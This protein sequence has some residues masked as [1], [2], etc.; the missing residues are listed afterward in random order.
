MDI[1]EF[2][3]G[4]N[5]Y[6]VLFLGSGFSL[7]YLKNSFGW[8]EL[9]EK[10]SFEIYHTN[11]NWYDIKSK[12]IEGSDF[13]L[14]SAAED[15]EVEFNKILINDRNGDF[16]EINDIF[17]ERMSEGIALSRFKIYIS[18]ILS[19]LSF[20]DETKL[21]LDEIK[22]MKK[23]IA[24]IITTNYDG[25]IEDVFGFNPLIGNNIL[26]SN[27]YNSLYKIHGCISNANSLIIT[28]SD[29]KNFD[30][31]YELIRA[32]LV[33]LF[34]HNP[35]LFIGYSV[36]DKNIKDILKTIFSYVEPN[37]DL[38]EKIRSN[39]LLVEYERG[40]QSTE[41]I[42]HSIDIDGKALITINK[43]KTDNFT[44]LYNNI[45]SLKL[46][47][48]VMDIRRVQSVFMDIASGGETKVRIID[49]IEDLEN[50]EKILLIGSE[51]SIDYS[52]Y[53][54]KNI[55]SNY[56]NIIETNNFKFLE[57]IDLV[58][59]SNN[60]WFPIFGFVNING[61][62]EKANTL[63]KQQK[64]K[65]QDYIDTISDN[66]KQTVTSIDSILN[67]DS[68]VKTRKNQVLIWNLHNGNLD[69]DDVERYLENLDSDDTE[70]K[71]ILC[72]FDQ[73]KY[74]K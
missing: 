17:Y 69:L 21:E 32:Q 59:I 71:R 35:I 8:N 54:A 72:F 37:S 52:H 26:L 1:K 20:R 36:S 11:D 50:S 45:S 38:E 28:D 14:A 7:R 30:K 70:Y 12:H 15:L 33:S 9:L 5:N 56:F 48:S 3:A 19:D 43:L 55:L 60:Q 41:I 22:K 67:D 44:E 46:P 24:S 61:S 31:R 27:P 34:I 6:P 13:D 4:Y 63:K 29:Y 10:I 64:T 73:K 66:S 39:F 23:N 65:M 49:N 62:I 40:T 51:K 2:I 74:D 16:K 47:A 68:I 53:N 58:T 25:L 42:E 18:K 57:L